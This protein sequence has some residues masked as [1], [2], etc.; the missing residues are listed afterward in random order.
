MAGLRWG[1]VFLLATLLAGCGSGSG[2]NGNPPIDEEPDLEEPPP[3]PPPRDEG[4]WMLDLVQGKAL[5][6]EKCQGCHQENGQGGYGPALTN[7][8][9]CPPCESFDRLWRRI[10]EFMPLRNPQ[11]CVGDCARH[12][13]AWILND[14]STEPSCSIE[15]RHDSLASDRYSASFRI[16]NQR[17]RP[18]E[19]WR[20]GF[21]LPA[22]QQIT[23][24][25]NAGFTQQDSRVLIQPVEASRVIADGG[26]VEFGI[27]ATHGGSPETPRGLRLEAS[28]CFTVAVPAPQP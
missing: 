3:L 24:A 14:F 20:L 17:G 18:V 23:A 9:T 21:E 12:I 7:T 27:E 25:R 19:T 4:P 13:A 28:P 5:Y 11:D 10:D 16:D 26:Y 8:F 15:F 6:I 1:V 22:G 2:T